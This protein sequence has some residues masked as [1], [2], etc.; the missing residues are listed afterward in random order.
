MLTSNKECGHGNYGHTK[1]G[2]S[3]L[4]SDLNGDPQMN[5]P[6]REQIRYIQ[7]KLNA[8]SIATGTDQAK[9]LL[10]DEH[11]PQMLG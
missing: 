9:L 2:L 6:A 11:I 1:L 8:F 3:G 4:M 10:Q 5:K 7:V